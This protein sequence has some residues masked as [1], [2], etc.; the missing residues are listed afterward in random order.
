MDEVEGGFEIDGENRVPLA[1]LHTEH[2]GVAG[3]AGIVDKDVDAA[4]VLKDL[5]YD[6]VGFLEGRSVG[7][8]CPHLVAPGLEL[9][10]RVFVNYHVGKGY[11][12]PLGGIFQGDG[13]AYPPGCACNQRGLSVQKSHKSIFSVA[14]LTHIGYL[15][16]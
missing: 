16:K 1:F 9:C 12:S 15:C 4:E 8:I 6:L 2:K 5:L 10:Y 11:V 14:N 3:D 7:D 13:L